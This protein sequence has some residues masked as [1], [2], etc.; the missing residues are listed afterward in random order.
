MWLAAGGLC[1]LAAL[2]APF[3]R[4]SGERTPTTAPGSQLASG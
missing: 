2:L 4:S 3:A 1:L